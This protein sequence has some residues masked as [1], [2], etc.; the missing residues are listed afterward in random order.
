MK[1]FDAIKFKNENKN[2]IPALEKKVEDAKQARRDAWKAYK[3]AG[4]TD[5]GWQAYKEAEKNEAAAVNAL[6]DATIWASDHLYCNEYLYSDVRPYEVMEIVNERTLIIREMKAE[7]KKEAKEALHESFVPG[8][9][10][11]H[12]NNDLQDWDIVPDEK[13]FVTKVRRHK[14]GYFY[15]AGCKGSKFALNDKPVKFYD[16]NF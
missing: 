11:G 9:F 15:I 7:I 10:V 3:E 6:D 16:Y 1:K 8:G 13:G 5:E 2:A 12:F 14:D 4:C